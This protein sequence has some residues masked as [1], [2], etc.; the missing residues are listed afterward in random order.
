[1]KILVVGAGA[2]GQVFGW[3]LQ[4]G[5]AEVAFLVKPKYATEARAGFALYDLRGAGR[6]EAIDFVPDQ[7]LTDASEVADQ[8]WDAVLVTV[9][10][11]ALRTGTWMADLV[12]ATGD[13]AII[14]LQPGLGDPAWVRELAGDDRVVWGVI[15]LIA[16][17]APLQGEVVPRPGVAFWIPRWLVFPYSGPTERTDAIVRAFRAGGMRA[18]R[19]ADVEQLTALG[20]PVMNLHIAALEASGWSLLA[21]RRD[22]ELL[23][24]TSRAVRQA[25]AVAAREHD[26]ATPLWVRVL[27]PWQIRLLA[28]VAPRVVPLDLETYLAFHFTKVGEQTTQQL[29]RWIELAQAAGLD[30]DALEALQQRRM[31]MREQQRSAV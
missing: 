27:R 2:V 20:A 7:V 16:Y 25:V 5:G 11:A 9:S 29:H 19:T 22:T 17:Q 30:S 23:A 15:E 10:S 18:R 14:G 8:V 4:R 28:R 24:L 13:A 21:V 12:A 6:D 26:T 1:M 3:H 31:A